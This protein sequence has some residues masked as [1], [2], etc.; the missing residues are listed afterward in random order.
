[1]LFSR[2]VRASPGRALRLF[3]RDDR[4][5]A[6][7]PKGADNGL[8]LGFL[9]DIRAGRSLDL[10][11]EVQDDDVQSGEA[12]IG[13]WV[14]GHIPSTSFRRGERLRARIPS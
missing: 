5:L 12:C 2:S 9:R 14:F 3:Q 1:V 11:I 10:E 7:L 6:C 4:E 13:V 8:R